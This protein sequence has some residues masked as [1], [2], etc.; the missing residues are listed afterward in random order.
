MKGKRAVPWRKSVLA[1]AS[2]AVGGQPRCVGGGR[3]MP[4]R[5]EEKQRRRGG[6]EKI[7]EEKK[8][9]GGKENEEKKR[10]G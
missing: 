10:G 7:R 6:G 9:R 5:E 4:M 2:I 1:V 8:A 3:G